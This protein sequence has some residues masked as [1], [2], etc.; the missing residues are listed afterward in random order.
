MRRLR[1]FLAAVVGTG[2]LVALPPTGPALADGEGVISRSSV[3]N[4]NGQ[5]AGGGTPVAISSTG[6]YVLWTDRLPT[7]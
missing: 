6:R 5:L 3:T 1:T 4:A 2:V 7:R